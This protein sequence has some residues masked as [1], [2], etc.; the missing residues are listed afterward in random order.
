MSPLE[1]RSE[2][3]IR[4]T[5][6]DLIFELA[7]KKDGDTQGDPHLIDEL[8]Y[9]SLA[10]LELAF[11]LEDEFDLEPID[12]EDA[13]KIVRVSDVQNFVIDALQERSQSAL[14]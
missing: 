7:P 3:E 2:A 5:I 14:A 8:E 1:N 10:I 11:T 12:E 4:Q 9:H 13:Q 6:R